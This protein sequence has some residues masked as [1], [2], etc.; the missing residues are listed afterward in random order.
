MKLK[1]PEGISFPYQAVYTVLQILSLAAMT[2]F[3]IAQ[4]DAM[5]I[6]R[7]LAI[8]IILEIARRIDIIARDRN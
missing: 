4:K 6:V 7:Y 5:T 1:F 2:V 3:G 8:A